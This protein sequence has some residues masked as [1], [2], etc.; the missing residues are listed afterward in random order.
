MKTPIDLQ[1]WHGDGESVECPD[2]RGHDA[3][4]L[5]E[6]QGFCPNCGGSFPLGDAPS[7]AAA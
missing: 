1:A 7:P 4:K 3:V 6:K 5:N 2:C